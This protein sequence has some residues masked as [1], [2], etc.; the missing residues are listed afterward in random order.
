MHPGTLSKHIGF[1]ESNLH[2]TDGQSYHISASCCLRKAFHYSAR[3]WS[4]NRKGYKAIQF[5]APGQ[6][7]TLMNSWLIIISELQE[8]RPC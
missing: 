6:R 5:M 1:L 8:N 4:R 3:D 7:F 2:V